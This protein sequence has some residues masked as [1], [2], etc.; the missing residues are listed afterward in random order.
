MEQRSSDDI[1]GPEVGSQ[2]SRR[3]WA[4]L[5]VLTLPCLLYAIDLTVLNLALPSLSA[6]LRPTGAELLWIVD[7]YGFVLASMLITMGRLGDRIGHRRLLL[8]G[9]AAFEAASV[10]AAFS[11]SAATLIAARAIL[12][13]AAATFAPTTLSMIR[14]MFGD[15]QE[16]AT[17]IGVWISSH[18]VGAAVGPVVGGVLLQHFWW[19]SVFLIGVP[20]MTV[21]LAVGPAVLP[22]PRDRKS[23]RTDLWS[24]AL[25]LMAV[26]ATIYGVKRMA[27]HGVAGF[28]ATC[29]AAG[30]AIG[31]LFVRRQS[32]LSAPVI[33]PRLFRSASFAVSLGTF[34][35]GSFVAVGSLVFVAQYMQL[36]LGLGPFEAGL[37]S[38]PFF[39][40]LIIGSTAT[41][42]LARRVR[43]GYL[44]IAGLTSAAVGFL[45]LS[46]VDETTAPAALAAI[47]CVYALGL[48]PIF[49]L[50][51]NF[52]VCSAPPEQAATASAIAETG[53]E[54]G[55]ALG[56]AVLGSIVTAMYR[57]AMIDMMPPG[58]LPDGV[59]RTLGAA[60]EAAHHIGGKVG[61]E[62]LTVSRTAFLHGLT[63]AAIVAAVVLVVTAALAARWLP[64]L[65][66][67]PDGEERAG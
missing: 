15:P 21:L 10:L 29:I 46:S 11:H 66:P 60:I 35:V 27:E 48:A 2:S 26:L 65:K 19:G 7:I 24:C 38:S 23:G 47:S 34:T 18:S 4:G 41:P 32:R 1:L 59:P 44:V 22:V 49:T 12:G 6:D 8:C 5:A 30:L 17:A 16:R 54:F 45:L 43:P 9:A 39:I 33:D 63:A 31:W 52:I 57:A 14:N 25:S 50:S 42:P 64:A 20:V 62:I 55:G 28:P 37:W 40:A 51:T 67:T 53:S 61:V 3:R 13:I 58:P 56:I 36:V